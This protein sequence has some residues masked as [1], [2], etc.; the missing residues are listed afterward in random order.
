MKNL[1][2]MYVR[3]GKQ[4]PIGCMA[5]TVNRSKNRVEYGLSMRNPK[6]AVDGCNHKVKF[7]R[8]KA[9]Q[10]ALLNL[11]LDEGK[12]RAYI[13][14][15]ATMHEITA[16]VMCDVISRGTAPTGAVKFAKHWLNMNF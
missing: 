13:P 8:A 1:R 10:I 16:A 6:D 7:D 3:N 11:D 12:Q 4:E 2:F 15:D 9:Q 5:I 14:G